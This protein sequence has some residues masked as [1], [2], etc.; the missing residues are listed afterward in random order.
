L[1]IVAYKWQLAAPPAEREQIGEPR[2][3]GAPLLSPQFFSEKQN[4]QIGGPQQIGAPLLFSLNF[5]VKI[6][7]PRQIWRAESETKRWTVESETK[8]HCSKC[9]SSV[10]NVL[11]L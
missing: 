10:M 1:R 6:S 4:G 2:Q 8:P 7:E 5:S 3:I 11:V 9:T